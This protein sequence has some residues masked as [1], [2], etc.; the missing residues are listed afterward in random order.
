MSK[1]HKREKA[2]REASKDSSLPP[3][4]EFKRTSPIDLVVLV[5]AI[6]GILVTA[7]L[8]FTASFEE[9]P[10]FCSEGSGC[11]IV[12]SSRWATFLAVPMAL[13]G[14]LTYIV[15]AGLS[16]RARTKLG[17]WTPLIFMAFC[18]FAISAYLTI[19]S[20]VEIEATCPYC[21]ASF[22]IITTIM[23]L[24]LVRQPPGW[25][26]S[27]KEAAVVAV[28]I[29]GA[30]HLHYSGVFDASAGPEDPQLQALA[31]HLEKTGVKFYGAYWCPR[32]QEQKAVFGSSAK[33]LPYVE[34]SSGGR[35]SALTAPCVKNDIKSYPTWII[36]EQRLTGLV[37][38]RE[39]ANASGFDW[40]E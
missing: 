18:G 29:V 36:G 19:V 39:L 25:L 17:S 34:C 1:R 12:Q 24:T 35:G 23:I 8:T 40:K 16:W 21:L 3:V 20:V 7:Y 15:I 13:W 32:C 31:T 22:A 10:A 38:P 30:L 37:K 6:A 4:Q 28:L 27:V 11:D 9:H 33:R 2:S 5:L 26:T 14:C